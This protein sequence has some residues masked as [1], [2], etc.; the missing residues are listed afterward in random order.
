MDNKLKIETP[1]S[2]KDT[3]ES[4][5]FFLFDYD[6]K[7]DLYYLVHGNNLI[8]LKQENNLL[9]HNLNNNQ[10]II[11]LFNLEQNYDKI[12]H[13]TK[14]EYL[15]EAYSKY[16]GLKLMKVDLWQTIIGFVCSSNANIPKIKN[17]LKLIS[18]FFGEVIELDNKKYYTFP[19]PGKID[20]IEL[21]IKAK[22]GYRSKY[23]YAINSIINED[24]NYLQKLEKLTYLESKNE[25]MKLPGVGPKV[26]DCI[27]LFG[28]GHTEAFPIDTW[29][30]KALEDIYLKEK[31]SNKEL[32]EFVEKNFGENKGIKQQIIFHYIRNNN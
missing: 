12:I 2:L 25:L 13:E 9:Y 16:S 14:D 19:K 6:N 3:L 24:P 15:I 32:S 20:D 22:T 29:I 18:E 11:D 26:A 5:Q 17:N 23:I 1:F 8:K 28:L 10:H 31:V 21:L 27:C 4:G 7:N 30:K